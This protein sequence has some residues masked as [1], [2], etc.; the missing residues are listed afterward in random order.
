MFQGRLYRQGQLK[1]CGDEVR[2]EVCNVTTAVEVNDE[3]I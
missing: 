2:T 1:E 3:I